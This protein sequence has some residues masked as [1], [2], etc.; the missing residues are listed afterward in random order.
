MRCNI[1]AKRKAHRGAATVITVLICFILLLSLCAVILNIGT[2]TKKTEIF[3]NEQLVKERLAYAARSF[4]NTA[5]EAVISG[6]I[7]SADFDAGKLKTGVTAEAEIKDT[8]ANITIYT[9]TTIKK[10]SG[11]DT[12]TVSTEA[13]DTK[14]F[15][16]S[17]AK[18]AASFN[19][20]GKKITWSVP[21]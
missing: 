16:G 8:E 2:L 19:L 17:V 7:T 9:K 1:N 18:I 20:G 10:P 6:D 3:Q 13:S 5:A 21:Q 14:D 12:Y 4:A 11:Y 15:K